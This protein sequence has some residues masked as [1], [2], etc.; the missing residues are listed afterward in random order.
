LFC[1]KAVK[2]MGNNGTPSEIVLII[3]GDLRLKNRP[4]C[5]RKVNNYGVK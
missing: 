5:G 2:K 4:A 1:L 3:E